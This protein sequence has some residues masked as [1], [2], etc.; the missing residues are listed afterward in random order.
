MTHEV[1]SR[2]GLLEKSERPLMVL[3]VDGDGS[4]R[5][6]ANED[7]VDGAGEIQSERSRHEPTVADIG[8]TRV[9]QT[10]PDLCQL[11]KL[12]SDPNLCTAEFIGLLAGRF[13]ARD[14]LV[15]LAG[16]PEVEEH[17]QRDEGQQLEQRDDRR[18]RVASA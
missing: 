2:N 18:G 15:D 4:A 14:L 16:H 7:V 1:V 3:C 13:A 10:A 17:E 9:R 8:E 12:G 11:H 6:T 5:V